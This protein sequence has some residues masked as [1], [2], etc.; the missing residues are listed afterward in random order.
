VATENPYH[1][2]KHVTKVTASSPAP[3][4]W[5]AVVVFGCTI[6]G[7]TLGLTAGAALGTFAP[8]Y[9]RAVFS[10]GG[11]PHFDPVAVGIGQGVTQGTGFGALIGLA[12]V[13]MFYWYNTRLNRRTEQP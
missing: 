6:A 7:S 4:L 9:Y 1:A 8:G 5:S 13:A 3:L 2:P 10:N 12:L 11:E